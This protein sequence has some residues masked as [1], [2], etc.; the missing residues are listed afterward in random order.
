MVRRV[1]LLTEEKTC[2]SHSFEALFRRAAEMVAELARTVTARRDSRSL[3]ATVEQELAAL[4]LAADEYALVRCRLHNA[5][6]YT[7]EGEPGAAGFELG[8]MA[9]CLHFTH[10]TRRR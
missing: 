9:K 6:R 7:H 2:P 4:P 3:F 5:R 1:S 10:P 8:L